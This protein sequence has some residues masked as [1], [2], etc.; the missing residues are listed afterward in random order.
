MSS[1]Q[2]LKYTYDEQST[3]MVV[4]QLKRGVPISFCAPSGT[5]KTTFLCHV[6]QKFLSQNEECFL[7]DIFVVKMTHHSIDIN[8]QGKDCQKYRELGVDV[9]VCN[10]ADKALEGLKRQKQKICLVEGGRRLKLP[11]FVLSRDDSLDIN[12]EEPEQK[13]ILGRVQL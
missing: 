10:D 6:I 11:C 7:Q 1:T 8:T 12:W 4:Q 3:Q 2:Y 13:Y 9:L 5:G